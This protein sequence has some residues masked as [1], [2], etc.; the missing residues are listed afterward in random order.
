[1][2]EKMN[3][4]KGI[5][6]VNLGSPDSYSEVD[7]RKYLDEFLMD[8]R[9]IDLPYLLRRFI[10]SA[11]ILPKRPKNS[12]HAYKTI[13]WDEG[14]PL[15]VLSERLL[16][17][18]RKKVSVPVEL[19]M[20]YGNP[21][22]EYGVKQ[23]IEKSGGDLKEIMLV[24]LYPHY[25]MATYETVVEKTKEVIKKNKL[26]ITLS[27]LPPFYDHPDY[28]KALVES[29]KEYLHSE[30]DHILFSFHGV[31]ER[32]L[33]KTDHTKKHCLKVENC[34]H[35]PSEAHSVCYRHQCIRT[36][37]EFAKKANLPEGKFSISFQSRLGV[38]KWLQPFTDQEISRLAKEGVKKMLLLCPAFVSDCLETLE[39]IAMQGKETFIEAGGEEFT[40]ILCL[41][42]HP[43]WVD[44]LSNWLN[45]NA[46]GMRRKYYEDLLLKEK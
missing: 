37:E 25:A 19:G 45:N 26:D 23:L 30:Y 46:E 38:D 32:H 34:C 44:T 21:S 7:V 41:N 40:Q 4:T 13:W 15:I 29:A 33:K 27:L 42:D 9:V 20:R 6:L 11:F 3:N 39:E 10:L 24:P 8:E 14:S 31:P 1:M 16:E 36:V 35:T 28:I 18:V 12:A 2:K 17:G 5:L 22:I 43:L